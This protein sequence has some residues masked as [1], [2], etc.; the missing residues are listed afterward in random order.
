[1]EW[2]GGRGVK[3]RFNSNYYWFTTEYFIFSLGE[4]VFT[5]EK[6][7]IALEANLRDQKHCIT[8]VLP[9]DSFRP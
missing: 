1:M 9:G 5:R 6:S 2:R 7:T 4:K 8:A 3:G